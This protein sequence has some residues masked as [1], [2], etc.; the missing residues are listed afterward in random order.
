MAFQ[1]FGRGFIIMIVLM[2]LGI[3]M[4]FAGGTIID[5]FTMGHTG[6][7][8]TN[9]SG[10]TPSWKAVQNNTMWWFI[11]LYYGLC[12]LLPLLGIAVFIQSI[13]PVTTGDR[14]V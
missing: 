9:S 2:S 4:S 11:N 1:V 13:L 6:D 12:Y 14:Y 5:L 7:L 8:I 10:V 3:L